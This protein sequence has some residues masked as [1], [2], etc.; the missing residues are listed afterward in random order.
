M[1]AAR[2]QPNAPPM[3]V[4]VAHNAVGIGSSGWLPKVK[5]EPYSGARYRAQVRVSL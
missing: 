4:P 3:D 1:L 5:V 2:L